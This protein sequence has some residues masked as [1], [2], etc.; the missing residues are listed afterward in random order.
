MAQTVS[1]NGLRVLKARYLRR[2]GRGQIAETPD[3]LFE[4][5]A[6]AVSEAELMHGTAADA[7]R[8]ETRFHSM[9]AA[10]DFLPNSPR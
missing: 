1:E 3:Q 7:R 9:I 2:D 10:L 6:R 4:R 8:W 5:V